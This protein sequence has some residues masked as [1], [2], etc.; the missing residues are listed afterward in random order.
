MNNWYKNINKSSLTPPSYLFGIV[1]P[2]LYTLMFVSTLMVWNNKKCFPYCY[3]LTLF[4]IQLVFNLIWTT[5]FFKL[6]L[7]KIALINLG[8][9]IL[10]TFLTIK[11]YFKI[12]KLSAY[13]LVPYIIWLLFAFYLNLYITL[14]NSL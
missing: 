9:I 1:W 2:I 12:N 5:L 4:F 13:L 7:L 11:A 3:P 10:F 8:I 6:R 14:N